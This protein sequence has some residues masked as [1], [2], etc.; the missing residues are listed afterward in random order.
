MTP[1]FAPGDPLGARIEAEYREAWGTLSSRLRAKLRAG[2]ESLAPEDVDELVSAPHPLVTLSYWMQKP[3]GAR[4]DVSAT[5]AEWARTDA[6][7]D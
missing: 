7:T 3:E 1:L 2:A 5:F 4:W 6:P